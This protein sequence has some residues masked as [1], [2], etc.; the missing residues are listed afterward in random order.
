MENRRRTPRIA[1]ALGVIV[2]DENGATPATSRSLS[3]N[4]MYVFTRGRWSPESVLTVDF[5]FEG[6]L[7]SCSARV[8]YADSEGV[9]L[10]FFKPSPEFIEAMRTVLNTLGAKQ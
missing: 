6:T 7:L 5:E 2:K 1:H 4:G 8:A 9:G 10:A 3:V